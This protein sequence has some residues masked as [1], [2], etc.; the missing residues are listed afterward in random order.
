M[1]VYIKQDFV[2]A[3]SLILQFW[4]YICDSVRAPLTGSAATVF[5]VVLCGH[6]YS[7]SLED[8]AFTENLFQKQ[9]RVLLHVDVP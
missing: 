3:A 7:I 4:L 9:N 8:A 6:I 1:F 5:T 2:L